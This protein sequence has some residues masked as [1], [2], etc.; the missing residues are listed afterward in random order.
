MVEP[1]QDEPFRWGLASA[2]VSTGDVQL[3][4]RI[5]SDAL[6]QQLAQ[7]AA[8]ELL[9]SEPDEAPAWCPDRLRLTPVASTPFSRPAAEE[10]LRQHYKLTNLDGLGLQEL[11]LALRAMG[12]LLA[13]LRDTQPLDETSTVPLDVPQIIHSGD[14][15][16]LD[17]QSR[18]NLELTA[19]QRR[20]PRA[21]CSGPSI[22]P[23]P[24]WAAAAC[25]VGL[26][27]R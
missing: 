10:S 7:L 5:D 17:A 27:H 8:S 22:A 18:R 20:W 11:P 23:S 15:L 2:D 1:V 21:H 14:A 24:P 12:G 25:A 26:R 13:Y 19:T 9:W 3:M 6:H 16:V 4:Q